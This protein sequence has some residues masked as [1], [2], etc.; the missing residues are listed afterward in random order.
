[1]RRLAYD[2]RGVDRILSMRDT[3][4][5]ED[6]VFVFE[7][8]EAGVIAERALGAQF[9]QIDVAFEDDFGIGWDFELNRL[10]LY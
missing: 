5:V 7:R 10:A 3:G 2:G 4:Y 8:V 9:V 1:M 6:G